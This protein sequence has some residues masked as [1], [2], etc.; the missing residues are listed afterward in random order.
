MADARWEESVGVLEEGLEDRQPVHGSVRS[1]AAVR[2]ASQ[3][4]HILVRKRQ[5]S[6]KSSASTREPS[7]SQVGNTVI[8]PLFPPPHLPGDDTDVEPADHQDQGRL[9]EPRGQR[10]DRADQQTFPEHVGSSATKAEIDRTRRNIF[11]WP[12]HL[13]ILANTAVS[14]Q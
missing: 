10:G 1:S 5:R 11:R 8:F 12:D 2:R 3:P 13:I 9:A 4:L 7:N 14:F 6:R